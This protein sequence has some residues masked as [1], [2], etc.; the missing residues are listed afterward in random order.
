MARTRTVI[1][2]S[3]VKAIEAIQFVTG[4]IRKPACVEVVAIPD[5]C[6]VTPFVFAKLSDSQV[7]TN[8]FGNRDG[9][10]VPN[11]G[12]E[13]NRPVLTALVRLGFITEKEAE[14]HRALCVRNA[15]RSAMD[16]DARSLARLELK[17][18]RGMRKL[19]RH[20]AAEAKAGRAFVVGGFVRNF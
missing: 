2:M 18:G 20:M 6:R 10:Y 19:R 3:S 16:S 13:W 1:L 14:E 5:D 17:Y 9:A 15:A 8:A 7:W 11:Y 12:E 4:P